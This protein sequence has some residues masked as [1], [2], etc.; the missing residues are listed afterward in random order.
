MSN[1]VAFYCP[2]SKCRFNTKLDFAEKSR[3]I[4][5]IF[6]HDYQE[7][8]EASLQL[9]IIKDLSDRRS[10]VYLSERLAEH[11]IWR[12]RNEIAMH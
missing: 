8:L 10:P 1:V 6:A 5:H 7:K 2:I 11:G 4:K 3:I 12:G 9:G